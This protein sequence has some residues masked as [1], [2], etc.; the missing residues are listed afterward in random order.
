MFQ[1]FNTPVDDFYGMLS[2]LT[3][4]AT[5]RMRASEHIEIA[6]TL[7]DHSSGCNKTTAHDEYLGG[8]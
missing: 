6:K 4:V 5:T 2:N 3:Y 8:N 7:A 1:T